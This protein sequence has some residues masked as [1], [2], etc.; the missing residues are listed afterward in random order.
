MKVLIVSDIHANADALD[1]IITRERNWDLFVFAGDAVGRGEEPNEVIETLRDIENF[2]GVLGN[3]DYAVVRNKVDMARKEEDAEN[4]EWTRSVLRPENMHWL[5]MLPL[6][7][8]VN[9]D[10]KKMTVVHGSPDVILYGYVYPWTDKS[11]LRTYLRETEMLVVGH[12]HIPF[13]YEWKTKTWGRRSLINPGSPSFPA[14][15]EKPSYAV[16]DTEKWKV[17]I[18][19][20]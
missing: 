18:K 16:L 19:T 5:Q 4:V 7:K 15:G 14:N 9:V 6:V 10:G 13:V 8:E 20:V 2:V 11:A 17:K 12:T 3:W 1:R